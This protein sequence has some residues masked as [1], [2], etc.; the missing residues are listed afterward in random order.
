MFGENSVRDLRE[1][2]GR[3]HQAVS[4]PDGRAYCTGEIPLRAILLG[5]PYPGGRLGARNSRK[6]DAN[7][8][9]GS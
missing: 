4:Q 1:L 3:L 5:P 2:H 9:R 8:F 7:G 6:N